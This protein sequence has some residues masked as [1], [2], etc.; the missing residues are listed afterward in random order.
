[1]GLPEH[2]ADLLVERLGLL[3]QAPRSVVIRTAEGQSCLRVEQVRLML[4]VE[5]RE[6]VP[7]QLWSRVFGAGAPANR[8]NSKNP[9]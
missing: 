1:M 7:N 6:G 2:A 5:L 3:E 4:R 8:R 9:W